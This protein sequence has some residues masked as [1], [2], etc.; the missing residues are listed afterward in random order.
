MNTPRPFAS[1]P[2]SPSSRNARLPH[3]DHSLI[4][5]LGSGEVVEGGY[6][7]E[8]LVRRERHD[9]VP[10]WHARLADRS[11]TI[12]AYLPANGVQVHAC[13]PPN[14]LVFVGFETQ[15]FKGRLIATLRELDALG[16]DPRPELA[17]D[18]LPRPVAHLPEALDHLADVVSALRSDALR[19]ALQR[20][21]LD[22]AMILDWIA[23]PDDLFARSVAAAVAVPDI[24]GS[25]YASRLDRET[26]SVACLMRATGILEAPDGTPPGLRR[27]LARCGRALEWLAGA[28]P[29]SARRLRRL[30]GEAGGRLDPATREIIAAVTQA[31]TRA[32]LCARSPA[33]RG[34]RWR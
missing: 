2:A 18:R 28:D 1:A 23:R 12:N 25:E 27:A 21:F 32:G 20:L 30:L 31:E 11:G 34:G 8:F 16:G 33:W 15:M 14:I 24:L 4:A 7:L 26:A 3:P 19:G 9:R 6:R 17:L 22:D 10:A 29:V 13:L 5:R